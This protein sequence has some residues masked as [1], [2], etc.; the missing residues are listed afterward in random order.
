ML[1]EDPLTDGEKTRWRDLERNPF[2]VAATGGGLTDFRREDQIDVLEKNAVELEELNEESSV[3]ETTSVTAIRPADAGDGGQTD[4]R[5]GVAAFQAA[6]SEAQQQAEAQLRAAF[7]Q[8]R[9]EEAKR[10]AA[11]VARVRE[12]LAR[13]NE[14]DLQL[15]RNAA[16]DSI[17]ALTGSI[18]GG[19]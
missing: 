5:A 3:E 10:H 14:D 19:G 2:D 4:Q 8:V 1:T 13:Q 7:E 11:D 18:L 16:V 12:E 15:A 6:V 17:N 9:Q